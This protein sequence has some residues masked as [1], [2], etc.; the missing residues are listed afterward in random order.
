[1][2]GPVERN[3]V[4]HVGLE[5][6]LEDVERCRGGDG[7]HAAD[8]GW[9]VVLLDHRLYSFICSSLS[10]S[11]SLSPSLSLNTDAASTHRETVRSSD[12]DRR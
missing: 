12:G 2:R 11:L 1:M 8:S 3:S 10:L 5:A 9:G 4:V 7:G 6:R